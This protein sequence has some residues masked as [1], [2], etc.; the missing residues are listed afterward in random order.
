[1]VLLRTCS[2]T[3]TKICFE[4]KREYSISGTFVHF[5]EL[6]TDFGFR[7][8]CLET[9]EKQGR[10]DLHELYLQFIKFVISIY[11]NI[12]I[13]PYLDGAHQ[14]PFAGAVEAGWS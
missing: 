5:C 1:M 10:L 14:R 13:L 3:T 6:F 8:S 2:F 7:Y 4:P 9:I 11:N 12:D